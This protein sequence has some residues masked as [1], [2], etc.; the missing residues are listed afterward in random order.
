MR[1]SHDFEWLKQCRFYFKEDADKTWVS[2]TD[3][4]FAYQNEY[5]GCTDRLVITPLTDR[6]AFPPCTYKEIKL[7][8]LFNMS[9]QLL[10]LTVQALS[11]IAGI[12]LIA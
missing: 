8:E 11:I 3:V 2:V 9:H 4:T 12:H 1:S 6:L 10:M 5:L 7:M